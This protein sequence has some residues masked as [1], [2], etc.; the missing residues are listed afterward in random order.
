M[1]HFYWSGFS[2][3]QLAVIFQA[4]SHPGKFIFSPAIIQGREPDLMLWRVNL[5]GAV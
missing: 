1:R 5:E 2:A 3:G 4:I